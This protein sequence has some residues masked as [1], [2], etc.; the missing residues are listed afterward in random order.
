[1]SVEIIDRKGHLLQIRIR[2]DLRKIDYDRMIQTARE[3]IAREGKVRVLTILDGFQGWERRA[4]WG[5]VSFMMGDGENIEKMAIVGEEKWR[6]DALM[7]TA[8]GLRPTVI[9]FFSPS[10]LADAQEWLGS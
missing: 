10:R 9:E 4:D 1:M 3:V 8:A 6:D 5:D 2:G 7:F